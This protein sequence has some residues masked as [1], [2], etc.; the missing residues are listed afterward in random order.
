MGTRNRV[1][2]DILNDADMKEIEKNTVELEK[3]AKRAE[4]ARKKQGGIFVN[5]EGSVALPSNILKK[6]RKLENQSRSSRGADSLL[7]GLDK[8][9]DKK[10]SSAFIK[11]SEFTKLKNQVNANEKVLGLFG[12]G[13]AFLSGASGLTTSSGIFGAGLGLA[14]KI[15]LIGMIIGIATKAAERF[16]AQHQDGGTRDTRKA[17]LADDVSDI[18]SETESDRNSGRKLFLSN[19]LRNQGL[20]RGNSNTADLRDGTRIHIQRK[21]GSYL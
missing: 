3:L 8:A 14:S 20:P 10:S 18:G 21:Q 2:L 11:P 13:Q 9:K 19:P 5:D 16:V 12:R 17:V 1:S 15:P 7:A 6:R 4:I